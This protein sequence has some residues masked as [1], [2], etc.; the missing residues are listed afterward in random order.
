MSITNRI[1]TTTITMTVIMTND[2]SRNVMELSIIPGELAEY[3]AL[4]GGAR[5]ADRG[6]A[7]ETNEG[8]T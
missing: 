3:G 2:N 8:Q 1:T 7:P 5:S 4:E 6:P